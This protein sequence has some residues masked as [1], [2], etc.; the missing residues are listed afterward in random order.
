MTNPYL[1]ARE[2]RPKSER[3][4]LYERI[5]QECGEAWLAAKEGRPH[6]RLCDKTPSQRTSELRTI[7]NAKEAASYPQLPDEGWGDT[8]KRD[9]IHDYSDRRHGAGGAERQE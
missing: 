1:R 9:D 8:F 3:E 6:P 2:S 7:R 4:M 5:A